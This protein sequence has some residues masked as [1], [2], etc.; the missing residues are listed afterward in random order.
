MGSLQAP[1][2]VPKLSWEV[3]K[4]PGKFQL[5]QGD[6]KLDTKVNLRGSEIILVSWKISASIKTMSDNIS[7]GVIL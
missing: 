1:G 3:P 4:R 7:N 5:F 2:K 6:P